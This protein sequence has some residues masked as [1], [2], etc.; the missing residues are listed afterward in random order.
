VLNYGRIVIA[1][2]LALLPL[3]SCSG[4]ETIA[5]REIAFD[6]AEPGVVGVMTF[7]I[8]NGSAADG[9]NSWDLRKD[10]VF[11]V[12]AYHGPDVIGLQEAMDFQIQDI[13]R[14][15][16]QY[17]I[18][19]A[20]RDDGRRA[21]EASPVLYRR[22]RF[23]LADSGTFWFSNMPWRPGSKHWGNDLPRICT[24]VRLT[25]TATGKSFYVYNLHL[26]HASQASRE[27][28]VHLLLKEV[29]ARK[30]AAP[31]VVMGDFN[32]DI[33]NPAMTPLGQI[34]ADLLNDP[35]VDVWSYLHPD[36]PSVTTFQAFGAEPQGPCL[37]H[38]LISESVEI[39]EAAV[40]ARS[41]GGRYPSDHFPVIA[42][43]KIKAG[44]NM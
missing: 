29:A 35:M 20:G 30:P 3:A 39:I 17:A 2:V 41:F 32:M 34:G 21:G 42:T 24:W 44:G 38:I 43:V 25:E 6:R 8:R 18:V 36:Q 13:K 40:D 31:A 27:Y 37:D 14:A 23:T 12:L 33:D 19:R 28:S 11:D 1:C 9:V 7:N 4:P 22:D 26:D 5:R 16:P 10:L 15:L